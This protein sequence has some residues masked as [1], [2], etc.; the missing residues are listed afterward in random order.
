MP[1]RIFTELERRKK[2]K[3]A[4]RRSVE[5]GKD[6]V[7]VALRLMSPDRQRAHVEFL[8]DDLPAMEN[9][10]HMMD[11]IVR[12]ASGGKFQSW[13]DLEKELVPTESS[14][15]RLFNI[16]AALNGGT[17]L[18]ETAQITKKLEPYLKMIQDR[19]GPNALLRLNLKMK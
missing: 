11:D 14:Y 8:Q 16:G 12:E 5:T 19:F 3:A 18:I 7:S 15:L 10:I 4:Y 9:I 13:L 6:H 17:Q 2:L 1:E